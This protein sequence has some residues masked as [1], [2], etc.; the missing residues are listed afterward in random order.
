MWRVKVDLVGPPFHGHLHPLIG[1]AEVL[2]E[3]ADVRIVTTADVASAVRVEGFEA[4]G[5]LRGREAEVWRIAN[6]PGTV[7][8]RP[9]RMW[10]Q[11]RS[12][13]RLLPALRK[14]VEECWRTRKPE[15]AIVDFTLPSVG[16]LAR[17]LGVRWWTSHPSPL[18]IE[19]R[20]GTPSYFGGWS[21]P[22]GTVGRWRDAAG[23]TL[24]RSFKR[25]VFAANATALRKAGMPG[26]Y[27]RD[28]TEAV[29]SDEA[30]LALGLS[31]LE[32][33]GTWP[34][35]VRFVGPVL[36]TPSPAGGDNIR[37][38]TGKRNV[39]VTL[40]THL[41]YARRRFEGLVRK[42]GTRA[43][44]IFFHYSSGGQAIE[45]PRE[46]PNWR[47]HDY[48]N[49]EQNLR[50]CEAVVHHAGAGITY[51]CLAAGKPAVVLPQDYDQFDFAARLEHHGLAVWCRQ[52]DAATDSLRDV[53]DDVAMRAQIEAVA[54]RLRAGQLREQLRAVWEE[55]CVETKR[56]IS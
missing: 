52:L 14:D 27:R 17:E 21:P 31:E 26:V 53:L 51:H 34:R 1:I 16:W 20:D 10:R 56:K 18:V 12:N 24:V 9:W 40:G 5:V 11:L 22:R 37:V 47:F 7:R 42:W 36:R 4:V 13:L 29:Y 46:G 39:L 19:T 38:A 6:T 43:P 8:S 50:C 32:L 55:L 2:R 35:V 23:R 30:V 25:L 54:Q 3:W 44:E 48:I 49:Y 28:G 15:L 33:P 41:P 45:G